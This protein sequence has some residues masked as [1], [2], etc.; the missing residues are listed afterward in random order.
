MKAESMIRD[1]IP[2][3]EYAWRGLMKIAA[4]IFCF[5]LAVVGVIASQEVQKRKAGADQHPGLSPIQVVT[6]RKEGQPMAFIAGGTFEMGIGEKELAK[7][8]ERF[9]I[10]DAKLFDDEKPKHEVSVGSFYMDKYLVT[11]AEF[12]KFVEQHPTWRRDRIAGELENGHYLEHWK[13]NQIPAGRGEHPVVNVSWYAAVAYCQS[14][15][16]RLPSEAEWEF[17]AKGK[18]AGVFPWGDSPANKTRANYSESGIGTTTAVGSYPA[19]GYG[20]YDMAGDVWE[21][22]ADEWKAYAPG[23]QKNPVGG[24]D[25]FASGDRYLRVRTRRVIRGGSFEGAP[26]N[27]WVEYRDSH[28]P[29]NAKEFVGFRCAKPA[30]K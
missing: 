16:K 23:A 10:D 4:V 12:K 24:G 27:L 15:G 11:N 25:L 17:A 26:M 1:E 5:G 7:L 21:Y 22:L 20:L 8:Q 29:E 6:Q 14:E 30:E 13:D 19:N 9:E 18:L 2:W 3:R 28:P